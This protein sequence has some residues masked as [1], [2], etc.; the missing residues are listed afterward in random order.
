MRPPCGRTRTPQGRPAPATWR[1]LAHQSDHQSRS[2]SERASRPRRCR[3][4]AFPAAAAIQ[5]RPA[6]H[7]HTRER[8]AAAAAASASVRETI[9]AA[10]RNTP[11]CLHRSACGPMA[12]LR[13]SIRLA[14]P[15]HRPTCAPHRA[16]SGRPAICPVQSINRQG[17][18]PTAAA[19]RVSCRR[20]SDTADY[21]VLTEY[22]WIL[23][24]VS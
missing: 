5:R 19:G 7:V 2:R 13:S 14:D 17:A 1:V 4:R 18:D 21:C 12:D 15:H 10:A 24:T 11:V 20:G 9:C 22:Y 16:V 8:H 3:H 23:A 6:V